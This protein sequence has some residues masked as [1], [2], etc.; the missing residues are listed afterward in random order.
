M[1]FTT[2]GSGVHV[3][4]NS[5][6]KYNGFGK[7]Y[8]NLSIICYNVEKVN[9]VWTKMHRFSV[10]D[11]E[12]QYT[13]FGHKMVYHNGYLLVS[14]PS[15]NSKGAIYLLKYNPSTQLMERVASKRRYDLT[16]ALLVVIVI[17]VTT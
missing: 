8:N 3:G 2:T 13:D 12:P 6:A 10:W 4:N 14:A 1:L 11:H 16:L 9:N 17:L 7:Y 15:V 5:A